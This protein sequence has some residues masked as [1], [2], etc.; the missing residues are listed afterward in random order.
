MEITGGFTSLDQFHFLDGNLI[1][2]LVSPRLVSFENDLQL[3]EVFVK[4][5]TIFLLFAN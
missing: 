5:F 1:N 3:F 2:E 4:E